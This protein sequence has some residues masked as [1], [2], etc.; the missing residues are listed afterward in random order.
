M[1]LAPDAP[2]GRVVAAFDFD[3]TM[4]PGDSLLRFVLL[5]SGPR[6]VVWALLRHGPGVALATVA[7]VGS[8]DRAKAR[9][10]SSA[11]RGLDAEVVRAHGQ[12]FADVLLARLRP[13]AMARLQWHRARGDELV[14]VSASLLVYLEPLGRRLRFDAVLA[15]GLEV[16]GKTLT[17]RLEG[18]NVRGQ[19][20]VARLREWL[21]G[22]SCELWAYGD[23]AGDRALLA[24]ADRGF[25]VRRGRFPSATD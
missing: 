14:I 2:A 15:T 10:V 23:S 6:R 13:E 3:G 12:R 25:R 1:A 18:A 7:G 24:A 19:E 8:R 20:K 4:V 9:F 17:G 16:D 5:A 21:A 22:S 11:L